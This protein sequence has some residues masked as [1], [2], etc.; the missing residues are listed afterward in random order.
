M[1]AAAGASSSERS[2]PGGPASNSVRYLAWTALLVLLA[3][4][5]IVLTQPFNAEVD[6]AGR[7]AWIQLLL[8]LQESVRPAF[9]TGLIAA[10]FF[11]RQV[12]QEEFERI[13]ANCDRPVI[14]I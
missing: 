11:S 6:L 9:A 14:S 10:L 7:P 4:E 8:Y 12:L 3:A 1:Q 13:Q 5:L 2:F